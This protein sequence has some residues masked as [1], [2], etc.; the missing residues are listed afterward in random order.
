[1]NRKT[2]LVA[3][4][5]ATALIAGAASAPANAQQARDQ[6]QIAGSSTVLPFANVVAEQFGRTMR[7]FKT[8]IVA[9][10]GT[11]GGFREFC[12]G[13]GAQFI[14]VANASRPIT[15]AET[16]ECQKNGVTAIQEVKFGYDGIVFASHISQTDIAFTTTHLYLGLAEKVPQ[17][18]QLVANPYTRWNQI[19]PKL[20]NIEIT[21]FIPGEKHG[22]RE[23]FEEKVMSGGC[24]D[25]AEIKAIADSRERTAACIRVRK[26]GRSNDIDGDYT[27]TLARIDRNKTAIGVF[28]L[29]FYDQNKDK[30]RVATVNG[31][32]PTVEAIATGK[33]PVSRPLYFYVKK[34]HI[35]VIPGLKEYAEFFLSERMIGPDGMVTDK[36][37]IPGPDAERR[38][39]RETFGKGS[40]LGS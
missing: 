39:W 22:T 27:E 26:D 40:T 36:G 18:G 24:R 21:A 25:F 14:D 1:L 3:A 17:N 23:V 34:Q 11:G 5:A 16:A 28:G 15:A 29:S 8:P 13:I 19:D 12:R 37:L 20:P 9:S 38:Q 30:I 2:T 32:V 4:L 31:I 6:V 7:Q 35:G 10:G 33:Y